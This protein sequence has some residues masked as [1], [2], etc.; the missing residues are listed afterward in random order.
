LDFKPTD[1]RLS[2]LLKKIDGKQSV[3]FF[4]R[5]FGPFA[6]HCVFGDVGVHGWAEWTISITAGQPVSGI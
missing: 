2:I 1:C 4:C 3:S 6:N 5:A